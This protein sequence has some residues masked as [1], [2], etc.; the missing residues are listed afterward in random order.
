[1][2]ASTIKKLSILSM[3]LAIAFYPGMLLVM[4]LLS[5]E[6]PAL[7]AIGAIIML[8]P[9]PAA[10][11]LAIIVK[12]QKVF[13]EQ[14]TKTYLRVGMIAGSISLW[15]EI[16]SFGMAIFVGEADWSEGIVGV[17][18]AV[19][20]SMIVIVC[21]VLYNCFKVTSSASQLPQSSN[22]IRNATSGN[23]P[24][25]WQFE[26]ENKT[27]IRFYGFGEIMRDEGYQ[28][29][30]SDY[31]SK[32]EMGT[33]VVKKVII[34]E[35]I[36]AINA[37]A[38]VLCRNIEEIVIPKTVTRIDD[39]ALDYIKKIIASKESYAYRYYHKM[40]ASY[41]RHTFEQREVVC[42]ISRGPSHGDAELTSLNLIKE[43]GKWYFDWTVTWRGGS[44]HADGAGGRYPLPDDIMNGTTPEKLRQYAEE[45]NITG[46]NV[47]I[48]DFS[49]NSELKELIHSEN[50]P[51]G[52]VLYHEGSH[53]YMTDQ[54][55]LIILFKSIAKEKY[56][57]RHDVWWP[58]VRGAC[59][60]NYSDIDL[61]DGYFSKH[62]VE[63]LISFLSLK[64]PGKNFD[65]LRENQ[66]LQALFT[67][68]IKSRELVARDENKLSGNYKELFTVK[69]LDESHYSAVIFDIKRKNFY[70]ALFEKHVVAGGIGY[71]PSQVGGEISLEQVKEL[72][73]K[74][75]DT[76]SEEYK[77]LSEDNL[78]E[79]IRK[80][81][82][83]KSL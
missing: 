17:L 20:A 1:M 65:G 23:V 10:V 12:S 43:A 82:D 56:Y 51:E 36:T 45:K 52:L 80:I 27:T 48:P 9:A 83:E 59:N 46:G 67:N 53:V 30:P 54:G 57:I 4:M 25:S 71:Y 76:R 2:K 47:T 28:V 18:S 60:S 35:G 31:V 32:Y 42:L 64:F 8:V 78:Q 63:D 37:G 77:T 14:K 39:H 33:A 74:S 70:T 55:E 49:D 6:I 41:P 24:V 11:I 44:S 72:A 13:I 62:S 38:F 75:E 3:I 7:S 73:S 21:V 68:T 81:L 50:T 15:I 66:K 16:F 69:F 19:L 79:I 22:T 40:N 34:N 29:G 26:D 5:T 58:A 61:E